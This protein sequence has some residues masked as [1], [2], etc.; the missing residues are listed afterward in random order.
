MNSYLKKEKTTVAPQIRM[1]SHIDQSMVNN[2]ITDLYKL[3][4][5]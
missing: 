3:I 1:V 4:E 5:I 2:Q